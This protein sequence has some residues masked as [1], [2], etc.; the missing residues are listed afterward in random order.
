MNQRAASEAPVD[1]RGGIRRWW[2][3]GLHR[4][5]TDLPIRRGQDPHESQAEAG[6]EEDIDQDDTPE[7]NIAGAEDQ[8]VNTNL[9]KANDTA[10]KVNAAPVPR[11]RAPA[12]YVLVSAL[13]F[14]FP[15]PN[16]H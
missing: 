1:L 12:S 10:T 15:P 8:N 11:T 13:P 5:W 2:N 9:D 6:A 4:R 7:A 14:P 3:S 16:N